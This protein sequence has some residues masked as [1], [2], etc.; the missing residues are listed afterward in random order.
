MMPW[1]LLMIVLVAWGYTAYS[2]YLSRS[3][4]VRCRNTSGLI[5]LGMY[6]IMAGGLLYKDRSMIASF[7]AVA[8]VLSG[9]VI[10]LLPVGYDDE[11]IYTMGRKVP[12]EKITEVRKEEDEKEVRLLADCQGKIYVLSAYTKDRKVIDDLYGR[13]KGRQV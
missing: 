8:L 7:A 2:F 10:S 12:F 6:M 4:K 1:F 5:Y 9:V 3:V 13:L 11:N